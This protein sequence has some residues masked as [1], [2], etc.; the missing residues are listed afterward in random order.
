ML[1]VPVPEN[2]KRANP[3]H[4]VIDMGPPRGVADADC[5]TA[6]MLLGTEPA[7]PGFAGRDQLVYFKPSAHELAVLNAGGLIEMN[8]VGNVVQPFALNVWAADQP[9]GA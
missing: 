2:A 5:G 9:E 4:R 3:T 6:Q 8:Q 1:P 7:M